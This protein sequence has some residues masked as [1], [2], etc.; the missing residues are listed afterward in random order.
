MGQGVTTMMQFSKRDYGYPVLSASA[1]RIGNAVLILIVTHLLV[2]SKAG[3]AASEACKSGNVYL[4]IDTGSMTAAEQIAE[5]LHAEKIPATFF[6]AN[7]ETAYGDRVLDE[8]WIPFWKRLVADG[9]TFGNHTWSHDTAREDLPNGRL[10]TT[11][12]DRTTI[13]MDQEE[14]CQEMKRV[15]IRF[16]EITGQ[17]LSPIWRAPGGRTTP[18]LLEWA[19]QCGFPKHV[20][21]TEAGFLGDELSSRT[22]P[23]SLLLERALK[24]IRSG[25]ILMMHLGIR[26]RQDPF[27]HVFQPLVQGL[28]AK[29]F[30]FA[31][32]AA[33]ASQ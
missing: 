29:G 10:R 27:V 32:I 26:S 13:V 11:R 33:S 2:F 15:D 1:S 25:D 24:R 3:F 8:R 5:V 14:F 21:W 28:K 17:H 12:P 7:E 20:A 6:I 30:C 22:Y 9:H 4:T 16:L 31:P 23:N 18:R 19:K